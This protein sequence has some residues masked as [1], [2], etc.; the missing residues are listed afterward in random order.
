MYPRGFTLIELMIVLLIVG[1]LLAIG[2]PAYTSHLDYG[3]RTD[4]QR[5]LLDEANRLERLYAANGSY[6]Q[7]YTPQPTPNYR[8][9]YQVSHNAT[10]YVLTAEPV[11]SR[12]L[13][14]SLTLDQSGATTPTTGDCW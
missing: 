9:S 12:D 14:G 1:L 3:Y 4:A 11:L 6:P 8:L 7:T 2:Y 13:C 10:R 5:Q